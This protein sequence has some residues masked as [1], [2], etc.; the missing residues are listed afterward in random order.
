MLQEGSQFGPYQLI[1]RIAFGGMAEIHLAKTTGLGGF[2]KLLALKVIHPKYS[3]D[4]EFIDMLIDE[5]KIAVQLSH[6]NVAQ[7]FDLGK[8]DSTYYIA[9]EFIDGKDLYQLLVKC[10]EREIEIPFD[11]IAFIAMELAAGLGYA[12]TK[13]DNYGR[14]LNLIHRD[15]SPQNVLISFDGEVKLVDFGIA[16]ASQRSRE[17]ESGVIKGKFFYMSPE[18]AWGDPVDARTDVFS[19]G[20]CLYEMITG[21]MLYHEEKALVLLD[22]VRKAE[23]PSMRERRAGLPPEL[24]AITLRALVRERDRRFQTAAE[25]QGAL[26]G[27]LYKNWPAFN[28]TRLAEFV[29]QVFGD[30]RFVLPMPSAAPIPDVETVPRRRVT[31][32]PV[33]PRADPAPLR[34]PAPPK[35]PPPPPPLRAPAPAPAPVPSTDQILM[36]AD[37]FVAQEHSVIF[38]LRAN[39]RVGQRAAPARPSRDDDDADR[40]VAGAWYPG[41]DRALGHEPEEEE[42]ATIA[43]M[44]WEPGQSAGDDEDT[45]AVLDLDPA[46]VVR[47][48]EAQARGGVDDPTAQFDLP[49]TPAPPPPARSSLARPSIRDPQPPPR[50]PPRAPAPPVP[51]RREAPEEA[52]PTRPLTPPRNLDAMPTPQARPAPS[53]AE[54]AARNA[55]PAPVESPPPAPSPKPQNRSPEAARPTL[56]VQSMSATALRKPSRFKR[57]GRWLATPAGIT[58]L[59]LLA[60]GTYAAATFLP[61]LL[62]DEAPRTATL[63]LDSVPRGARVT[64]DGKETAQETPA[65]LTGLSTGANHTLVLDLSGFERHTEVVN[66]SPE[67]AASGAEVRRR[68]FLKKALGTLHVHSEPVGAEVYLDGKYVGDTPITRRNLDRDKERFLLLLRK[69]GYREQREVVEWKDQTELKLEFPLQKRGN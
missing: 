40:T 8:I 30:Q 31:P 17:T 4:Q 9:M 67:E 26:T 64:L 6:V 46:E 42:E 62:A 16:K 18:Q 33:A 69:D 10:S 25:M 58:A 36:R 38:D 59:V 20:I 14:P 47:R 3:Q 57:L 39:E 22:K 7:I 56:S 29:R 51:A 60:L 19:A 24:E 32:E 45:T 63:V 12:H 37:D 21:E 53:G 50:P 13:S 15:V 2:E 44:V 1:K 55:R 54:A 23:I 65:T 43:Q 68:I 11:V 5:A 27:F 66:V 52:A 28:R 34:A 41:V 35:A 49:P 48:A 61:T